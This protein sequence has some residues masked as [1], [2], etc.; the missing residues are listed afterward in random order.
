M[1]KEEEDFMSIDVALAMPSINLYFSVIRFFNIVLSKVKSKMINWSFSTVFKSNLLFYL[2]YY[3]EACNK[4]AGP[5]PR[6]CARG[7]RSFF[8][9]NV[10]A[11][12]HC[13][14]FDRPDNLNL[15]LTA[16]ETNTLLRLENR[17]VE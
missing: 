4:F 2:L 10:A 6:L 15:R 8:G 11:V 9:R 12:Q 7:Q 3:V 13:L 5:F 1:K 16:P 17:S 14:K